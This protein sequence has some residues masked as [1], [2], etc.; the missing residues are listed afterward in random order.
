VL[1]TVNIRN[2]LLARGA[3]RQREISTRLALGASRGR[4]ARQLLAES[5]LLSFLGGAAALLL[6]VWTTKLLAL[7]LENPMLTGGGFS[8][9]SLA[10]D[11]RVMAYVA[12]V[13]LVAGV[14]FG[15]APALQFTNP[16]ISSTLK[17]E[18]GGL[19]QLRGSRVR[20]FLVASQVAVSVLLLAMQGFLREAWSGPRWR[21]R[22]SIPATYLWSPPTSPVQ[23]PSKPPLAKSGFSNGC[24]NDQSS[25]P[26][27]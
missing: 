23:T 8:A 1:K 19:G 21:T 3:A 17:T 22:D 9:V 15:I 26:W 14:L 2:M 7:A 12:A 20:S 11:L 4:I 10:P 18:D 24:V 25:L 16:D 13:A 5:I 6:S 27:R